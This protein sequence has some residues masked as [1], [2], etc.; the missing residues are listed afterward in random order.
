MP[1]H[2]EGIK[3]ILT[4]NRRF[5]DR[6]EGQDDQRKMKRE[7]RVGERRVI[8]LDEGDLLW[9]EDDIFLAYDEPI[10]GEVTGVFAKVDR[11]SLEED[12]LPEEMNLEI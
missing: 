6:R 8:Y 4:R 5:G 2:I 1:R 7:R 9:D 12:G 3:S 11:K 10:E